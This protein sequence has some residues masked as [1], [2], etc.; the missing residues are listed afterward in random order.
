MSRYTVL[1]EDKGLAF[2]SDHACGEFLM[3]WVR[4]NDPDVRKEQDNFGPDPEEVIIDEDTMF[5]GLTR[6]K[7]LSILK[8]HGFNESELEQAWRS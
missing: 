4:P 3:I 8:E 7:Y 6:E 1:H 2:G 5:T